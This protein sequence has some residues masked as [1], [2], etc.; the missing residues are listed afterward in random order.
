MSCSITFDLPVAGMRCAGCASRLERSLRE[1]PTVKNASVNLASERAHIEADGATLADMVSAIQ[2]AGYQVPQREVELALSGL[3]CA[4]CAGT[5]E[6]ALSSVPGVIVASVN[7]ASEQAHVRLLQATDSAALL[8][9]VKQAG[10]QAKLLESGQPVRDNDRQRRE[11]FAVAL[12][13]LLAFPLMLPMF[14]DWLGL[15]LMLPA[16]LQL[17]LAA[18][19]QFILGAGFYTGAWRALRAGSSNMDTLVALGTSAAFGLS[20]YLWWQAEAGAMPHLYFESAAVVIALVRLGKYLESRAK[21]KTRSAIAALEALRPSRARRIEDGQES[22]VALAELQLGDSI[23]VLPGEQIPVDGEIIDGQSAVDE[24]LLSGESLPQAKSPGSKVATG[25]INGEGRLL[26]KVT[27]LGGETLLSRIIR[28]VEDAQAAKAPIQRLVDRISAVFVP[29]VLLIALA[30]LLAWLFL[31]SSAQEAW[32]NAVSVLVIACPCALGLATPTAIMAGTGAA[33]RHGILIK[34]AQALEVAHAVQTVAF[35]K[36]G[37]LTVGQPQLIHLH[38]VEKD[39]NALLQLAGALQRGSEHPLA[40][41][42]LNVCQEKALPLPDTTDSK[43]LPGRGTQAKVGERLLLLGNQRLLQETI[44]TDK[45]PPEAQTLAEDWQSEGRTLSYLI[46]QSPSPRVLG[47]LAFGDSLKPQSVAAIAELQRRGLRTLLIS[48]D[49]PGSANAVA[50]AL[51][52]DE[53]LAEVLPADKAAKIAQLKASGQLVAMVGDGIND[54]PALAAADVGIAMGSGTDV[55]MQASGI[56]LMR[57]N[58]LLVAAALDISQR[59]FSKIRQNLF[60]AFAYNLAGIPL[61]ACGLLSPMLAGAAMAFSSVCVVSNAL[62]LS[63]W[64]PQQSLEKPV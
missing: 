42:V 34:D 53:V 39:D 26:I 56:T 20:L 60:W 63:R 7:L 52:I 47:L 38:T 59:T 40:K 51:N 35:D 31:G 18:P 29:S 43:A 1:Q 32:L 44:G 58:P 13:L 27:A 2:Q 41:A 3:R 45:L 23:A 6:R 17:V 64:K 24:A 33:A 4:S 54:A 55:A 9:A 11:S 12:A 19:V 57:G 30:T 5:V 25:S 16:W 46:E 48:G 37:T 49:N 14:A 15:H 10:Y 36:T 62:L 61:A 8:H 21:R 22:W 28:L 50:K